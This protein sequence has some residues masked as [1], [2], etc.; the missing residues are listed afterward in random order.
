MNLKLDQITHSEFEHFL[1][2]GGNLYICILQQNGEMDIFL[3]LTDYFLSG[4]I[5]NNFTGSMFAFKFTAITKDL[6]QS[7][8]RLSCR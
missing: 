2:G 8:C 6:F 1:G 4:L 7:T 5:S 3:F